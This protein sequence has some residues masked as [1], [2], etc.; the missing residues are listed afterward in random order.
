MKE[1]NQE[2][3]IKLIWLTLFLTT[4]PSVLGF[5]RNQKVFIPNPSDKSF[6]ILNN[7]NKSCNVDVFFALNRGVMRGVLKTG[8][9]DDRLIFLKKIDRKHP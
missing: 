3:W 6:E 8:K 5:L 4:S 2:L 7:Y 9:S 1:I